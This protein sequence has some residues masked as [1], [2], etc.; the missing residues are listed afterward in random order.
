MLPLA[1]PG[2]R[3]VATNSF[4]SRQLR[5]LGVFAAAY[6]L[7]WLG[8]GLVAGAAIG[9]TQGAGVAGRTLLLGLLVLVTVWQLTP[10]KR[11]AVLSCNATVP[12]PPF[13]LRADVACAEFGARQ[14]LR[15]LAACGPL[16]T[17]MV[18]APHGLAGLTLMAGSAVAMGAEVWS[19]R[20]RLLIPW[21]ALPL[22][23]AAAL[24]WVLG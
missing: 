6:L 7:P 17:L 13:G 16:M 3:H 2:A 4:R 15:C 21:L 11:Q 14:S 20:R 23:A 22:G 8:F 5:A 9:L 12:L 10:W 24:V 1:L 18:V 19:S